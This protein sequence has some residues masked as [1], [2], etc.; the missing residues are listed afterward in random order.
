MVA[1]SE[2]SPSGS[3]SGISEGNS[4]PNRV[5]SDMRTSLLKAMSDMAREQPSF[6]RIFFGNFKIFCEAEKLA[7]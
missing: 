5:K 4:E 7:V 1:I 2:R 6:L 3:S